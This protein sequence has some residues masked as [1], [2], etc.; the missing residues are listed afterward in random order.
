[1][2]TLRPFVATP[3]PYLA[4]PHSTYFRS[5]LFINI[6]FY[7]QTEASR[8]TQIV[9]WRHPFNLEFLP[10]WIFRLCTHVHMYKYLYLRSQ[11]RI[12]SEGNMLHKR[13]SENLYILKS[14]MLKFR[15]ICTRLVPSG[16]SVVP[17]VS[18]HISDT[19]PHYLLEHTRVLQIGG[20][21][22]SPNFKLLRSPRMDS[23][24]QIP[25]GC[26]AW[27]AST[28]TLFLLGS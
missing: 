23:R 6:Q 27:R 8:K 24:K 25:P 22:L 12:C 15:V 17:I 18:M 16:P 4:T 11:K 9:S 21:S 10:C 19:R 26:V 3:D 7:I 2:P 1:V 5:T 13:P 28:T 14:T 20:I